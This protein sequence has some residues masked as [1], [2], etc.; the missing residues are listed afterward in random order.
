M[1]LWI[2]VESNLSNVNIL[3]INL[4]LHLDRFKPYR[5]P[6]L[7]YISKES[8]HLPIILKNLESNVRRRKSSISSNETVFQNAA[9]YYISALRKCRFLEKIQYH[10]AI[11]DNNTQHRARTRK[12]LWF[13]SAFNIAHK[14]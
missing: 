13:N 10:Q 7:C 1:G 6:K 11:S 3:Y 5:K 14:I 2:M 8:N 12:V 9:L 4:D